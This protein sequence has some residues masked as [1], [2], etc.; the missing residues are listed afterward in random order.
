MPRLPGFLEPAFPVIKR[1]HRL[2]TRRVGAVTR[3][4]PAPDGRS[5]PATATERSVFTALAEPSAVQLHSGGPSEHLRRT[6]PAGQPAD[7]PFWPTF[8]DQETSARFTLE[9]TSGVLVGSYSAHITAGG[10]LDYET[11][12]Y[13]G[14]EGWRE[15]PIYL[16]PRLP[17]LSPVSGSVVSLATRGTGPNYYHALMDLLPRW[18][19][20]Q[21]SMPGVVPDALVVNTG[22]PFCRELL[23]L[24]GLTSSS[25]RLIESTKHL[26]IRAD[27]LLVPSIT[28]A[29][30]VAPRWT[31]QW[32]REHLP[33]GSTAGLPS[34]LYVTRGRGRNFRSV[35]N[36]DEVLAALRPLGFTVIDP[37][38]LSV[39]EQIDAFAAADVVVGVHGAALTNLNFS[40]PGVRVLEL[41]A[42]RYLNPGYWAIA[43]NV[44]DSR[45]RY[46]VCGPEWLVAGPMDHVYDDLTVDVGRLV[47]SLEELLSEDV[48]PAASP[49]G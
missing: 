20:L 12:P 38:R 4:V 6:P 46:L 15:H 5:L 9:L 36:E 22:T 26:G 44:P 21:E 18:G 1:G 41:F 24:V 47:D 8:S 34:R 10:V 49:G 35:R 33:P 43:S 39:Q 40:P 32:L 23:E 11:S 27:R 45:Y 25:Y 13:F 28:N 14:I 42:P 3:A 30:T 48:T 37:G 7:H 31:T 2:A 17:R 29:R 19:I 16:R